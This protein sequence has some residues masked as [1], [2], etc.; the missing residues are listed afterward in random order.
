MAYQDISPTGKENEMASDSSLTKECSENN[1]RSLTTSRDGSN[2]K[3]I[4]HL[5]LPEGQPIVTE[6][7]ET[8]L[9]LDSKFYA[10]KHIRTLH[11]C[12]F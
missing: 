7:K 11:I 8:N 6:V 1:N 3:K 2:G 10:Y 9:Q 5:Q 12:Y 4:E